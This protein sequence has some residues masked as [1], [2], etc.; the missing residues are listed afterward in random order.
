MEY[1]IKIKDGNIID[2]PI[3]INNFIECYPNVDIN[4]LPDWVAPF[5]KVK[6]PFTGP[7]KVY[8]GMTYEW[9]NGVVKETHHFRDMSSSEV[10]EKQEIIKQKWIDSGNADKLSSWVFNE[11]TCSFAPPLPYPTG[12]GEYEWDENTLSWVKV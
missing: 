4:N 8:E 5:E 6:R 2:H 12:D 3:S 9:E 11:S 1:V 10:Q 7:Y